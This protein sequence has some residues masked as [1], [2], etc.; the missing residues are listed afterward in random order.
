MPYRGGETPDRRHRTNAAPY[1]SS[2]NTERVAQ[3]PHLLHGQPPAPR[4]E[5]R[6]ARATAHERRQFAARQSPLLQHERDDLAWG[7]RAFIQRVGPVLVVVHEHRQEL[8]ALAIRG[9]TRFIEQRVNFGDRRAI[10]AGISQQV[11][12]HRRYAL[13]SAR[14]R[15]TTAAGSP[16]RRR[17]RRG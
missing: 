16:S 5:L 3:R 14:N 7:P 10:L 9:V 12:T 1:I 11:R 6:D 17:S 15:A 4:E 13:A 2:R 8:Q